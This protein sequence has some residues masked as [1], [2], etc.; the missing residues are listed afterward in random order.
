MSDAVIRWT[1]LEERDVLR[2]GAAVSQPTVGA[3]PASARDETPVDDGGDLRL[4]RRGFLAASGFTMA[5]ALAACGRAPPVHSAPGA[6]APEDVVAG[7]ATWYATTC[8]GCAAGCGLIVR[9]RDGRP[10]KV[11]GNPRHPV[12]AGGVCAVGQATLLGL[13]DSRRLLRPVVDGRDATWKAVDERVR[14][15]LERVRATGG[16]IRLVT[17]TVN[18]P[19]TS[20]AVAAFLAAFPTARHVSYDALSASAISDAHRRTHGVRVVPRVFLDRAETILGLDADFLGTWI[21]PVEHTRGWRA[22]RTLG[23]APPRL[24]HH[25]QVE[26]ALTLTGSNADRR[27][28]LDAGTE[29]AFAAHLA[30]RL[31]KAAGLPAPATPDPLPVEAAAFDSV[32]AHLWATR[33]RSVVLCGTNDVDVQACIALANEALGAYGG[34]LDVAAPSLQR[35]GD[36]GGFAAFVDELEAGTVSAV[37]FAGCNPVA[38]AAGGARL[39]AALP[40]V[41]VRIGLAER[42]D[43]TTAALTVVTPLP[44]AFEAW[45]DA[46]PVRGVVSF[47]QPLVEPFG[48]PRSLRACLVAWSGAAMSELDLVRAT[49]RRDVLPRLPAG[50]AEASSW[51]TALRD[52]FVRVDVPRAPARPFDV[53]AAAAAAP[54]VRPPGDGW[55]LAC[56]PSVAMLDGRHAQNPWLQELPDPITKQTW[57]N[58]VL[59]SEVSAR[60]LRVADGDRVRVTGKDG[61]TATL[62][63]L[64]QPGLGDRTVV[65]VLGY[66]RAGTDRFA[67]V[68]PAW[69]EAKP[70]VVRGGTVGASATPFLRFERGAVVYGGSPVVVERA[71]GREDVARAQVY[72]RLDVPKNVAPHGGER[73]DPVHETTLAAFTKDRRAGHPHAAHSAADLWPAEHRTPGERWRMV[74]DL[75]ACTGCSACVVSCQAE[76]NIPVVGKDEV[77][78]RRDLAWMRIDRYY[79]DVPG[80]TGEVEVVHQPMLCQHCE[81]APCETVCP[82]LATVHNS[83]GTNGQVYNRCV[84]TRY[85]ANNCPYKVRRFNWFDYARHDRFADLVLNPDVTVR[86]R[87]VMEKCSM[88]VQRLHEARAEARRLGRPLADGEA[89]T[90]CQQSCPASAIVFG[91]ANDPRSAV[92]RLIAQDARH[93]RVLEELNVKPSVGYLTKVRNRPADGEGAE[94]HG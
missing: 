34:I 3:T 81:N 12:S 74:V 67:G 88:C 61:V 9:C 42:H 10:V 90:A 60:R 14:T 59:L 7:R 51:R 83:D 92:A 18:G 57:G 73:R 19:S 26:A 70:T 47:T 39:T 29:G 43:E 54:R 80:A 68:G 91:D 16:A 1:T 71:G 23:G 79:A 25:V 84:G 69:I 87:G 56:V 8:G 2:Q 28:R 53:A 93:Y 6:M 35:T 44:H 48:E 15:D 76:N 5:G 13:Y 89:R 49:W 11:E 63:A 33:G 78:R 62:P 36:D 55:V 65:L 27:V 58:A 4:S 75:T 82:V 24:S 30:A 45:D 46:E 38:D 17:G 37:I 31:A 41:A 85:C 50:A 22:G 32:V 72:D 21:S 66:G 52:G 64:I 86:T 94:R 77:F 40:R 20:A